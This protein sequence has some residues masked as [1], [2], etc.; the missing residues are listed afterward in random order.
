MVCGATIS[1][2]AVAARSA[3]TRI[4]R[5]TKLWTDRLIGTGTAPVIDD[6]VLFVTAV[7]SDV[8]AFDATCAPAPAACTKH[9]L[10]EHRYPRSDGKPT[11][12]SSAGAGDGNVYVGWNQYAEHPSN[13]TGYAGEEEA[14]TEAT[15]APVFSSGQGGTST[16]VV[17]GG[18]VYSD[19]QAYLGP[20]VTLTGTEALNATTGQPVFTAEPGFN[21]ISAP[22]VVDGTLFLASDN[23]LD[24]FDASGSPCPSLQA[25]EVTQVLYGL[26]FP[27]ACA[28]QWSGAAAGTITGTPVV[29]GGEVYVGAS[30]GVLYAFPEAGCGGVTCTPDWTATVGGSI[31]SSVAVN[32]TT[33]FVGSSAGTLDAFPV[34]GCGSSTCSPE[35]SAT[36]GGSLSTPTVDGSLIY[37]AS[38]NDLLDAFPTTGCGNP[39]CSAVWQANVHKP[40]DTAPATSNGVIFVTDT[41]HTLYAY[42]EP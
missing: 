11:V 19:W 37:V 42:R 38:T 32:G 23:S 1:G 33:V 6:G 14:F 16:S 27:V 26:G 8:Y 2:S 41:H 34:G 20:D 24:A 36:V 40:V 9:L 13:G 35:W 5:L 30:N 4:P 17:A 29:A 18:L 31:T 25:P 10:W 15:G 39:T 21:P 7:K 3:G 22:A 12:L 28:P